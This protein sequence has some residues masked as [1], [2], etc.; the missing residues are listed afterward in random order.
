MRRP[1]PDVPRRPQ[2]QAAI[3]NAAVAQLSDAQRVMIYRSHHLGWTTTQIAAELGT[4]SEAVKHELH[5]ALH[6]LR[7]T[8]QKQAS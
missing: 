7:M 4:T 6:A 5:H 2:P 3:V 8:L 1:R